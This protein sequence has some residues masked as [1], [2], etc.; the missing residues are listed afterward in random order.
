MSDSSL[1]RFMA[2]WCDDT[3][4]SS[5]GG[6]GAE[7]RL[8]SKKVVKDKRPRDEAVPTADPPSQSARGQVSRGKKKARKPLTAPVLQEVPLDISPL[9]FTMP[10]IPQVAG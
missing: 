6:H 7:S 3:R 8:A 2:E 10:Q 1:Q 4:S 5:I 9:C